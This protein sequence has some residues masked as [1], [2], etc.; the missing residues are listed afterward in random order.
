MANSTDAG[1]R[2]TG[3]SS[4]TMTFQVSAKTPGALG[5][6]TSRVRMMTGPSVG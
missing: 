6:L 4:R 2:K 1:S 3:R 5:R